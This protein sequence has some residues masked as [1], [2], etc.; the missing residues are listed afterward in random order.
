MVVWSLHT[1]FLFFVFLP[2][3]ATLGGHFSPPF[4]EDFPP[5]TLVGLWLIRQ[6]PF[7]VLEFAFDGVV[8]ARVDR[9][10]LLPK[11]GAEAL[12]STFLD[13]RRM[14]ARSVEE[15]PSRRSNSPMGLSVAWLSR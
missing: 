5:L 3:P 8:G 14:R 9:L 13:L 2:A 10:A 4:N 12:E 1:G 11:F 6:G 15:S 7:L